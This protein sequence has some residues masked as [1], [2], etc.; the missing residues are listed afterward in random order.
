[1]EKYQIADMMKM[2]AIKT[3]KQEIIQE[4]SGKLEYGIIDHG[5]VF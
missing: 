2:E 4:H 5:I 3:V 1:M